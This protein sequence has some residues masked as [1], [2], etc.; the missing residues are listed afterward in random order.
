MGE[1]LLEWQ[2]E[3]FEKSLLHQNEKTGKNDQDQLFKNS[4]NKPKNCN[5]LRNNSRKQLNLSKEQLL[6]GVI[7]CPIPSL[8]PSPSP[9][10]L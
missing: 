5:N 6:C 1:A 10:P 9:A 7:T 2:V 3:T 4:G 8:Q